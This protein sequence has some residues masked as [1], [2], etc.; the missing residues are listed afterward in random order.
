VRSAGGAAAAAPPHFRKRPDCSRTVSTTTRSSSATTR[1]WS[2]QLQLRDA[3]AHRS[4]GNVLVNWGSPKL[5]EAIAS[6]SSATTRRPNRTSNAT[7]RD[8]RLRRNSRPGEGAPYFVIPPACRFAPPRGASAV[9]NSKA[10]GLGRTGRVPTPASVR[11]WRGASL[12]SAGPSL[13]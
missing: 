2:R 11:A 8:L 6:I 1:Q 5:A 7:L 3:A 13:T 9:S 12:Q 10:A 4:S